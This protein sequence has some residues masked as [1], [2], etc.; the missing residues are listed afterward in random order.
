MLVW[1]WLWNWRSPAGGSPSG[2]VWGDKT[3]GGAGP[4]PPRPSEERHP[5]PL[6]SAF[7]GKPWSYF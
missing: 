7:P 6:P 2:V 5:H 3:V 4:A 1:L